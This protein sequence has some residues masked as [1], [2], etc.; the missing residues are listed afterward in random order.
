MKKKNII[1]IKCRGCLNV[2][3]VKETMEIVKLNPN[4]KAVYVDPKFSIRKKKYRDIKIDWKE[5]WDGFK[6]SSFKLK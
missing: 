3:F 6:L 2:G 4:K 5:F 1:S